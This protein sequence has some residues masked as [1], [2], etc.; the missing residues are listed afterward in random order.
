MRISIRTTSGRSAAGQADRLGAVGRLADHLDVRLVGVEQ[1]REPSP[2]QC[3]VVGQQDPDHGA[4]ST[5]QPGPDPKPAARAGP[6]LQRAAEGGGPLAH[7]DDAVAARRRSVRGHPEPVIV[8]LDDEV[9]VAVRDAHAGLRRP[10]VPRH[11]G[12]RLLHDPVGGQ[13]HARRQRAGWAGDLDLHR[14]PGAAA[15][16]TRSSSWP[17][18]GAGE[19]GASSS[20]WRRTPEHRSQLDQGF[21]AG[22]LDGRQR[23]AGPLGLSS[24]RCRAA[25]ACTLMREML[26]A[27]TSCSSRAMRRRSSLVRRLA[28]SSRLARADR[29]PLAPEP[30]H[31]GGT[32][33]HEQ[34]GRQPDGVCEGRPLRAEQNR[35]PE[36]QHVPGDDRGPGQPAPSRHHRVDEGDDERGEDGPARV[37]GH[38]VGQRR[39]E[40][41]DQDGPR[42]ASPPEQG[43]RPRRQQHHRQGVP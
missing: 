25:P 43:D 7:A 10:G 8:D 20:S 39:G 18:P 3:L 21:L 11:V 2:D 4:P 30:E 6:G 23:R 16:A 5:G 26:W 24:I 36:E 28:S 29:R 22:L 42:M 1:R 27:S 37:V 33:Q 40:H 34:P 14:Q 19:R 31:L 38:R 41:D 12:E 17:R 15:R 32:G 13:V 9:P 35:E